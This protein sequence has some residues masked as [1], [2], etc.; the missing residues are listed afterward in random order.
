MFL[1]IAWISELFR[2]CALLAA[3]S[4]TNEASTRQHLCCR[5]VEAVVSDSH[6]KTSHNKHHRYQHWQIAT[7]STTFFCYLTVSNWYR[8]STSLAH[9]LP[10]PT[11]SKRRRN[12]FSA[13]E[14]EVPTGILA[15]GVLQSGL[16]LPTFRRNLSPTSSGYNSER[17]DPAGI[18]R[19]MNKSVSI[20]LS[21]PHSS[22]CEPQ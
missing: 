10:A 8:L 22:I 1:G 17:S 18:E 15:H 21:L 5:N 20:L 7:C 19:T 13:C 16:G 11:G 3:V 9:L 4:S 6:V 12:I 14:I 2:S